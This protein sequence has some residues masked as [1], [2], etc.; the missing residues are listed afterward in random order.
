MWS[1]GSILRTISFTHALSE[2]LRLLLEWGKLRW[3]KAPASREL[4]YLLSFIDPFNDTFNK[5]L[6]N[7]SNTYSWPWGSRRGVCG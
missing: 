7:V 1:G 4:K 2:F 3:M 6:L 5:G